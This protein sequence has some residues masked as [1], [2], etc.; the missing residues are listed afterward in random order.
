MFSLMLGAPDNITPNGNDGY[1]VGIIFPM[2]SGIL[3]RV[4]RHLRSFSPGVKLV[5][6][7]ARI[8]QLCFQFTNDYIIQSD[9]VETLGTKTNIAFTFSYFFKI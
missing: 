8:I 3:D 5:A 1:M 6:R 2:T 9:L 7:L 4:V